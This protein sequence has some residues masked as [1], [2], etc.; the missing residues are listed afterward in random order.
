MAIRIA[1]RATSFAGLFFAA[2][3]PLVASG[4]GTSRD[5]TPSESAAHVQESLTQQAGPPKRVVS[6]RSPYGD[7]TTG[8]RNVVMDGDFELEQGG[9]Q[10]PWAAINPDG[11]FTEALAFLSGGQCRSGLACV[12]APA[13]QDVLSG[14]VAVRPGMTGTFTLA[15]KPASG[16]CGDVNATLSLVSDLTAT[17]GDLFTAAPATPSPGPDGWCTYAVAVTADQPEYQYIELDLVSPSETVYDDVA[18]VEGPAETKVARGERRRL[19]PSRTQDLA[20]HRKAVH[21]ARWRAAGIA[22][23]KQGGALGA[24]MRRTTR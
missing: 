16:V 18:L 21:E 23:R 10:A 13:G 12:D 22:T 4:C 17:T 15:A 9:F 20:A 1:S 19:D 2:S 11:S 24:W 3:L 6:R 7:V 8:A 14:N 5:E